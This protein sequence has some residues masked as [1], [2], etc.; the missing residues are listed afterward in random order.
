V[1]LFEFGPA[2]LRVFRT[3]GAGWI[4]SSNV[5][6][7]PPFAEIWRAAGGSTASADAF[8]VME[9]TTP[10][11]AVQHEAVSQDCPLPALKQPLP[12]VFATLGRH[13]E[14]LSLASIVAVLPG[15]GSSVPPFVFR[16]RADQ[17]CL[18]N[19]RTIQWARP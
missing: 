16:S 6:I 7:A 2:D 3:I 4:S 18:Y 5:M 19:N 17:S 10:A 15:G 13:E 12:R 9:S 8:L 1:N 11:G 14:L